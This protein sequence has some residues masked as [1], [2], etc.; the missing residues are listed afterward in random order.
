MAEGPVSLGELVR[1]RMGRAVLDTLVSP[2]VSGVH[3]ADPDTLDADTVDP[4]LRAALVK[5]GSL[6]RAVA[7]LRAAWDF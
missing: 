7:A 6:A 5:H 2:V 1:V 3:S 4:G